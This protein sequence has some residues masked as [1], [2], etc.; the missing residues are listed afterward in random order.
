MTFSKWGAASNPTVQ[1]MKPVGFLA[2]FLYIIGFLA[3]V[4]VLARLAPKY[5]S[6][7]VNFQTATRWF[8]SGPVVVP[9]SCFFG[10]F[11]Y[12]RPTHPVQ[13]MCAFSI[14]AVVS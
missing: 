2:I 12:P 9:L 14:P 10:Y 7:F 6:K 13:T 5:S 1:V 3:L 11:L 4:L 8:L